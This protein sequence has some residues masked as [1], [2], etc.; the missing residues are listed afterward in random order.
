MLMTT[1]RVSSCGCIEITDGNFPEGTMVA[2]L[3]A[4][5][6]ET[7]KPNSNDEAKL[8]RAI[9]E[10]LNS[11]VA[12]APPATSKCNESSAKHTHSITRE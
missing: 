11:D 3:V 10:T 9:A 4:E 8:Q 12:K 6:G 2:I 1:G 5:A 7:F